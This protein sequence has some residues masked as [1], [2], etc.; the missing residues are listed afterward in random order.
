MVSTQQ[1]PLHEP[2]GEPARGLVTSLAF[3]TPGNFAQN[4]PLPRI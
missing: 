3:L 1:A 2:P 4:D